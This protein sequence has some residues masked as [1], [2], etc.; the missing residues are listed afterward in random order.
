MYKKQVNIKKIEYK[1]EEEEKKIN[2]KDDNARSLAYYKKSSSI[3]A[4]RRSKLT[5]NLSILYIFSIL[6]FPPVNSYYRFLIH[7]VCNSLANE[8]INCELTTFSI[9]IGDYRRT[10]VCHSNQL[11]IY[12]NSSHKR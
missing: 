3:K 9:G 2:C 6:L 12:P 8:L 4:I 7:K 1:E 11:L 5:Q 10:V